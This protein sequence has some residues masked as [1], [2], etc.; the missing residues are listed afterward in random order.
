MCTSGDGVDGSAL[1]LPVFDPS[2]DILENMKAARRGRGICL[3]GRVGCGAGSAVLEGIGCP[4]GSCGVFLVPSAGEV[5][6]FDVRIALEGKEEGVA[7]ACARC[8]ED[9]PG[10][11]EGDGFL[12]MASR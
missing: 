8:A 12:E 11:C 6:G 1:A 9:G 2:F 3:R 4:D 7:G 5:V 10:F